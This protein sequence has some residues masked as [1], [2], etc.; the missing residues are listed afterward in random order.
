M[1]T[2]KKKFSSPINNQ[3]EEILNLLNP[4]DKKQKKNK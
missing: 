1:K 4:K 3:V 2:T